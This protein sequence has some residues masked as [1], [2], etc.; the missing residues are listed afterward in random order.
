MPGQCSS[1]CKSDSPRYFKPEH[2]FL[3]ESNLKKNGKFQHIH[4]L[5]KHTCIQV[6]GFTRRQIESNI[7]DVKMCCIYSGLSELKLVHSR[8]SFCNTTQNKNQ[9]QSTVTTTEHR[10]K[11]GRQCSKMTY[12]NLRS[13]HQIVFTS[14]F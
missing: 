10:Q 6:I 1:I 4:R 7:T 11:R 12:S 9:K 5:Q 8:L 3:K 2:C 14:W 13:L